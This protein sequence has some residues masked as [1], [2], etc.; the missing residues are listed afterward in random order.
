M[1]PAIQLQP[2]S[3]DQLASFLAASE[4]RYRQERAVAD[5]F[6]QQD[7]ARFV[8]NQR[9]ALLPEGVATPGHHFFFIVASDTREQVGQLWLYY[10]ADY[11][12][13]YVYDLTI[14]PACRRRGFGQ[15]ALRA[16]ET[17]ARQI[18]AEC[19]GLNVFTAN[20]AAISLYQQAGF[21]ATSQY[22]NKRLLPPTT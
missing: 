15:A 6:S 14:L 9:G 8:A 12:Q 20:Q 10:D 18:G 21:R 11:R 2:I 1:P 13:A 16:A 19:L 7:A 5:H 3:P 22:M 17:W 4:D